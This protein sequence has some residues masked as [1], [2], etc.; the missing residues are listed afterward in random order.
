MLEVVLYNSV[1]H[2]Q[3]LIQQGR[4]AVSSSLED[5]PDTLRIRGEEGRTVELSL[6]A[7]A[8]QQ[9]TTLRVHNL[10]QSIV[11]PGGKRIA[12]G[13]TRELQLPVRFWV[14]RTMVH[15]RASDCVRPHDETLLSFPRLEN[16]AQNYATV[17]KK[18]GGAPAAHTLAN[19]FDA[20]GR[21]QQS[22][23]GSDEFFA[24]AAFSLFD[25]G[26]LDVG[27]V[28]LQ[29]QGEWRIAA[30]YVAHPDAAMIFRRTILDRVIAERRTL[31]HDARSI[32]E[33]NYEQCGE[34]VVAAPI[35]GERGE[36]LGVM[37]GAR[38]D[39]EQNHRRGIRP[40]EAQFVQAVSDAVS[41]A[42]TRISKETEAARIRARM[43][44][45]FSPKISR[46][47]ERNPRLLEGDQRE[48]TVLFGDIR[49]FTTLSEQ[50]SPRES[51]TL[52]GDAM[53]RFTNIIMRQEGV[54]I[55]YYGDGLAAF[56]NA[57][58]KQPDHA[59]LACEAAFAMQRELADLSAD[60]IG[61]TGRNLRMGIG[62]HTG[63]ALVG[64]AGS[65]ARIKYGPR[66]NTVNLAARVENATKQVGLPILITHSTM[67][68]L[69][70]TLPTRR[71]FRQ[72]LAGFETAVDLYQ[73]LSG[74]LVNSTEAY[75]TSLNQAIELYETGDFARAGELLEALQLNGVEDAALDHLLRRI[76]EQV[77]AS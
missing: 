13:M 30:S 27:M 58:F 8:E 22:V 24:K 20:L 32:A 43:E 42:L 72:K 33:G 75:R 76:R 36:V 51:Y 67:L 25:P 50:L 55:D 62:I 35:F 46:E 38:F 71:V 73:P 28:L 17:M 6:E 14:G 47:L 5:S 44:Q 39:H 59:R 54:I 77:S 16:D 3:A 7:I 41:A 53:D 34:F 18:L 31:F 40:L 11:L 12:V 66:G 70:E 52:L 45:V 26:G 1:Q 57:P 68:A 23:A 10:G 49:G 29:E 19:W 61:L 37:Y 74:N 15:V 48:V 4:L 64:N 56:W 9:T 2:V 60:W 69:R 63:L 21:L 65:F